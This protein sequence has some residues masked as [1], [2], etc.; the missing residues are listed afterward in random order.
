MH[1]WTLAALAALA[2]ATPAHAAP[3]TR[4]HA[5]LPA[6]KGEA[7]PAAATGP[8]VGAR[9]I[10]DSIFPAIGNGG[11]DA[12]HYDLDLTYT[13]VVHS[14]SGTATMTATATQALRE[15]S[16]DFRGFTISALT[17]DGKPATTSR[18]GDKLI[19]DPATPL[20]DGQTFK[21]AVTYSGQPPTIT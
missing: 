18:D 10:G 11:Y 16:M 5:L 19:I 17:V 21:V 20:A 3:L 12:Q 2:A 8:D 7:A 14:L 1:R 15:F 13:P 9:S 6:A 4:A